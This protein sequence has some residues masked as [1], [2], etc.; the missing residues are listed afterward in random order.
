M[1]KIRCAGLGLYLTVL[2]A[3]SCGS[4]QPTSPG[5]PDGGIDVGDGAP[6]DGES[7]SFDLE[8][9]AGDIGGTGDCD[10][11]GAA[12]RFTSPSGIA[13]D[14]TGNVYVADT[15]NS[16][17]R[18]ITPAGVATTLAGSVRKFG[19]ADGT[20]AAARF[21]F[22]SGVAV[23]GAGNVY[24]ADTNNS[25]IR[26]ITP[27]GV[28]TTLA[29]SP[30]MS[31]GADG[32]GAAARFSLP[33]G[34]AV[35][36][37]GNVYI[38]DRDNHTIRRISPT[39]VV[40]TLA[41]TA[42]MLGSADGTG[43]AARFSSPTGLAVD[44]AGNVYVADTDNATIRRITAAGVVTT[45]AGTAGATGSADGTG[46]A[47]RFS[48]PTDLAT[49][50]A[51]NVY[52]ADRDNHTIRKIT[53]AGV[54][55]TLVG[56][57]GMTGSTDDVGVAARFNLPFGVVADGAGNLYVSDRSNHIIRKVATAGLVTTLAGSASKVGSVDDTGAAARFNNP[58][59]VSVDG[60]GNFYVADTTNNV[61]R[62]I[63]PGGV[64]TTLAGTAGMSGRTDGIGAA[65]RFDFPSDVAADSAGNLYVA[66]QNNHVIRKITAAGV[67][68]TLA[69]G[70]GTAG[71][72]DGTGTAARFNFPSNV[73][74]DS[75]GNIYVSDQNNHT[76]RRI[77]AAGLVTTL[78]GRV[79]MF[80]AQDGAGST[81]RFNFPAGL[82]VDSTGDVY[83]A[84]LGSHTIRKV[85]AAGI[86][87]T[88]VGVAGM[89]GSADG[90]GL[91]ARFRSPVD[92][93]VDGAGNLYVADSFNSTIRKVSPTYAASK[94]AGTTGVAGIALGA[95]YR[96]AFPRSLA[97]VGDDIAIVDANAVLVL[98]RR[99]P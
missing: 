62:K 86:V 81:A 89:V 52:V 69:G 15:N 64:A 23:D 77:T 48:N 55:T 87:T 58:T 9:L 43:A 13:V 30:G 45:L 65:A 53:N 74:I 19:S 97:I 79:G 33:S 68:T 40:T 12:A 88:L 31:G 56:A 72:A 1:K 35:D 41:G 14:G 91:E 84:D 49:D 29:G 61:I 7:S 42:G 44:G 32:T 80:G 85:T 99:A 37:A 11:T 96:F 82:A 18:K 66:D 98:R 63:T 24:V 71:S 57:A 95:T 51:G 94:L 21:D 17:I 39:G 67:V 38:A 93:A 54:V 20:G 60:A 92:V 46:A 78:A 70:A 5:L 83:V 25:T 75:A 26:K 90:T 47:A 2:A 22:P 16:T 27:T 59:G 3:A 28:V 6:S 50:G 76:L 4:V 34:A 73:A 8:L 10:G 36:I